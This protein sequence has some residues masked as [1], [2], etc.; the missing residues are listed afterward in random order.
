MA[1]RPVAAET[2]PNPDQILAEVAGYSGRTVDRV[3]FRG[4]KAHDADDVKAAIH[5]Q[6]ASFW[7]WSKGSVFMPREF[8]YDVRRA[9]LFY[10]ESGFPTPGCAGAQCPR[11][12]T[13]W[14][15]SSR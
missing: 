5:H 8:V 15:S 7:P 1:P 12:T 10:E 2:E 9:V 6:D 3:R 11:T 13:R 14:I 4:V